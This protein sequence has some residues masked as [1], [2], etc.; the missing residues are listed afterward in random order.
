MI[1]EKHALDHIASIEARFMKRYMDVCAW[2]RRRYPCSGCRSIDER[3][4]RDQSWRI[5][6]AA[7]ERY[8]VRKGERY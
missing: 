5:D 2:S 8:I 6:D 7:F 3:Y 1:I 4:G